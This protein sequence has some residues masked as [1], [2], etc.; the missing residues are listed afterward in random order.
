[1]KEEYKDKFHFLLNEIPILFTAVLWS[2]VAIMT[3]NGYIGLLGLAI[4]YRR[5]RFLR[6]EE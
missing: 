2:I 1:M 5:Y 6:V 3:H 4:L